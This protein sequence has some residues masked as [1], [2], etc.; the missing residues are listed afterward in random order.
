MTPEQETESDLLT[1]KEAVHPDQEIPAQCPTKRYY[2]TLCRKIMAISEFYPS[3]VQRRLAC[4]KGCARIKQMEHSRKQAEA[5]RAHLAKPDHARSMLERLRR[6]CSLSSRLEG[7]NKPLIVGFDVKVARLLL[8]I[9]KWQSALHCEIEMFESSS[10]LSSTDASV[11]PP[12]KNLSDNKKILSSQAD[13]KQTATIAQ[14][15]ANNV[16]LRW[17]IWA[18]DDTT[19]IAPWELIPVTHKEA[20]QFRNVPIAMR[21]QLV[22]QHIVHQIT[23]RLQQ[24]RDICLSEPNLTTSNL[25]ERYIQSVT[26]KQCSCNDTLR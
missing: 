22:P 16:P 19:P 2:C 21:S 8:A 25:L 9:W 14:L 13:D 17:I 5:A 3:Y 7:C 12:K 15:R 18:K 20:L 24:V 23:Q 4:C 26:V 11:V 1:T 10:E 6:R